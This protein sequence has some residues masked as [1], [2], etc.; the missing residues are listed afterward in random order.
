MN[1]FFNQKNLHLANFQSL[2]KCDTEL[3]NQTCWWFSFQCAIL[4]LRYELD[5]SQLFNRADFCRGLEWCFSVWSSDET[6]VCRFRDETSIVRKCSHF[7]QL[8]KVLHSPWNNT[9]DQDQSRLKIW[10]LVTTT[11]NIQFCNRSAFY[12]IVWFKT[13]NVPQG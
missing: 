6:V 13:F 12:W 8:F 4:F 5:I 11:K 7:G 2:S 1:L 3:S 10:F 9:C